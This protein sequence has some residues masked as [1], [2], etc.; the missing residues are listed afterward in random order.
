[1]LTIYMY[2][3]QVNSISSTTK[4]HF[5]IYFQG[6]LHNEM[7]NNLRSVFFKKH[8]PQLYMTSTGPRLWNNLHLHSKKP[9]HYIFSKSV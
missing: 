4:S 7:I 1:M 3:R 6:M 9:L 2:Y 8:I 5:Q